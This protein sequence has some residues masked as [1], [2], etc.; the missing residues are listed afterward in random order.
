MISQRSFEVPVGV[1]ARHV[2]LNTEHV[3]VLFGS[4]L[5]PEKYLS[6]HGEFAAKER[7]TIASPKNVIQSV[8]VLGPCRSKSQVELSVTD[9]VFLGIPG[10][11]RLSGD[12]EGTP[13]LTLIGPQGSIQLSEGV[14][15]AARH[16]HVPS[17]EASRFGLKNH[18]HV[19]ALSNTPRKINFDYVTVRI[20]NTACLELH[21]D[22]DEANAA[23]L[24]TG[25]LVRII[26]P[27]IPTDFNST[28]H[29]ICSE[30][31]LQLMKDGKML[32]FKSGMRIT[33]AALDLARSKGILTT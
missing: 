8:R 23:F 30:D 32:H 28:D 31:V 10:M 12:T 7:V 1:S 19:E 3:R 26:V 21:L 4:E 16:L 27:D 29:F 11:V 22:T 14:I 25:D 20:A 33:Q 17:L 15:V 13:G 5:H 9:T 2:H 18:Q 6:Q 24:K